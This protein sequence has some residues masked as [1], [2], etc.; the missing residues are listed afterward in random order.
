MSIVEEASLVKGSADCAV[1]GIVADEGY[2]EVFVRPLCH[3]RDDSCQ[4]GERGGS[5]ARHDGCKMMAV[6]IRLRG[7]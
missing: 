1:L 6:N 3:D 4:S 5:E 7:W 2:V